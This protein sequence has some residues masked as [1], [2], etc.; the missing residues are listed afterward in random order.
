MKTRR[1]LKEPAEWIQS[2]RWQHSSS[3]HSS[4]SFFKE[5]ESSS[6]CSCVSC[7]LWSVHAVSVPWTFKRSLKMSEDLRSELEKYLE[8]L[9]IQTRCVEHPPVKPEKPLSPDFFHLIQLFMVTVFKAKRRLMTSVT[10]A[11]WGIHVRSFDTSLTR[12]KHDWIPLQY[13]TFFSFFGYCKP[14]E[15]I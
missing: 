8:A 14:G 1:T 3:K 15:H 13:H 7:S 9:N 2:S 6:T 12:T 10:A 5:E 4:V 11:G